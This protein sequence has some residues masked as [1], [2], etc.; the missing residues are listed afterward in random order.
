M[1]VVSTVEEGQSHKA[2]LRRSPSC[3]SLRPLDL[4]DKATVVRRMLA[5]HRKT[6]DE[7]AFNNQVI[8]III[9]EYKS[10]DSVLNFCLKQAGSWP[11]DKGCS[12][13]REPLSQGH[14][15]ATNS[16][17]LITCK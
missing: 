13:R 5:V 9:R 10:A 11:C 2:L 3:L 16:C 14:D 8:L 7:S 12:R 17:T 6:L 4:L 15:P 1:F